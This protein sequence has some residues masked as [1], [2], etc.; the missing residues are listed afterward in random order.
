MEKSKVGGQGI[1]LS[2]LNLIFNLDREWWRL[3]SSPADRNEYIKLELPG[4]WEPPDNSGPLS[5]D[6]EEAPKFGCPH[7]KQTSK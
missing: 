3:R 4:A 1:I 7:G 2:I 6:K 5:I